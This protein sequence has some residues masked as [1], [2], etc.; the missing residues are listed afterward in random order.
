MEKAEGAKRKEIC[1]E[2]AGTVEEPE[3]GEQL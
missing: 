1:Q 2:V 3:L